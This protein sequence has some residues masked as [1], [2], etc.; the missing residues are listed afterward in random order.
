MC[1]SETW[2]NENIPNYVINIPNYYLLRNNRTERGSGAGIYA[3]DY[4][5][6][7]SE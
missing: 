2:L 4:L 5:N 7:S 3:K 6:T 1:V